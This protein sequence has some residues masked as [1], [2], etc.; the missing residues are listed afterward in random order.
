M[1]ATRRIVEPYEISE[2]FAIIPEYDENPILL[3]YSFLAMPHLVY[4]RQLTY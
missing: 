3:K 4:N 2:I 1:P